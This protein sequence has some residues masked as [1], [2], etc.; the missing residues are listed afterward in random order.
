MS[1]CPYIRMGYKHILLHPYCEWIGHTGEQ[2]LIGQT[3]VAA[4]PPPPPPPQKKKKKKKKTTTKKTNTKKKTKK[5]KNKTQK[6]KQKKKKKTTKQTRGSGEP[7]SLTWHKKALLWM[8]ACWMQLIF[9][10]LKHF[11][12]S[13]LISTM[14]SDANKLGSGCR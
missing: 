12:H 10:N 6:Q 2:I 5:T 9:S 11:A 3:S 1:A 13:D 4:W 8:S 7:V 14:S